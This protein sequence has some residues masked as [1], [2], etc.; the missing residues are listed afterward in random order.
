ME[1]A[2]PS[3]QL[4][5]R[6]FTDML[7][8][9]VWHLPLPQQYAIDT[10]N[11]IIDMEKKNILYTDDNIDNIIYNIIHYN[12]PY[13]NINIFVDK[14]NVDEKYKEIIMNDIYNIDIYNI[15][16]LVG[17]INRYIDMIDIIPTG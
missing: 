17:I 5:N 11:I 13:E 10:E 16:E 1:N 12:N 9:L 8:C 7:I 15:M 6:S 2:L 3:Y 4:S 14:L